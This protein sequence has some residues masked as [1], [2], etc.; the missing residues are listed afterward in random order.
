MGILSIAAG[1]A[2]SFNIG[3]NSVNRENGRSAKSQIAP[4][5][6]FK[7]LK[8]FSVA[9]LALEHPT[10]DF[11]HVSRTPDAKVEIS[12]SNVALGNIPHLHFI[13]ALSAPSPYCQLG[14][15][16]FTSHNKTQPGSRFLF[17]F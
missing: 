9:F 13:H 17:F 1:R 10:F 3:S 4:R 14:Q 15:A 11:I 12:S 2:A 8:I 5:V 16:P 6:R 7:I